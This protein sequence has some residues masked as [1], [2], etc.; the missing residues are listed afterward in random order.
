[1]SKKS[2]T[3]I[4][5]VSNFGQYSSHWLQKK[6]WT[7]CNYHKFTQKRRRWL[8]KKIASYFPGPFDVILDKM[9]F[10]LYPLDNHSDK[11]MF[12]RSSFHEFG[13]LKKLSELFKPGMV[14]VDI[15]ANIGCYSIYLGTK[16]P[17]AKA[18]IAL[19]PHPKTYKKLV[20]NIKVNSL[21]AVRCLNL[22]CGAKKG[23]E[24][25]WS[26]GGR[27]AGTNSLKAE[28]MKKTSSYDLV[29][30]MTLQEIL[31]HEKIARVDIIKVDIEGYED[32]A[33]W[34]FINSAPDSMLPKHLLIEVAHSHLWTAELFKVL[35]EKK[36]KL[37]MDTN[38]N[39]LYERVTVI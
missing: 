16:N 31:E 18:I 7:F 11:F 33:I 27:N 8:R 14:F 36:Y 25:L 13:E 15:G 28:S 3:K 4:D 12:S 19:E 39:H 21:S 23:T 5:T 34:P 10:R 17:K 26:E 35:K 24:K 9:N 38:L 29:T 6:I 32:Q 2:K 1:M 20:N 30:T 37:I 22:A